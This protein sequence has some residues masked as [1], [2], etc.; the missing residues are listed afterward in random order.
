M[1]LWFQRDDR[2]SRVAIDAGVRIGRD[3][4]KRMIAGGDVVEPLGSVVRFAEHGRE[5]AALIVTPGAPLAVNGF[6]PLPLRVLSDRDAIAVSSAPDEAV[7]FTACAPAEPHPFVAGEHAER[8]ARCRQELRAGDA[9]VRCPACGVAYHQGP[10]AVARVGDGAVGGSAPAVGG[11]SARGETR[12]CWSYDERCG[13]CRRGRA[14][15][16]WTPA[17]GRQDGINE[18]GAEEEVAEAG[19]SDNDRR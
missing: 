4:D 14:Q 1:D 5:R 11:S 6:S 13:A 19:R 16:A 2:W 10:L 3:A 8:C 15:M 7:V 17:V 18:D 12:E 9:S